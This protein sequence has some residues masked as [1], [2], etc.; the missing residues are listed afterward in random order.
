MWMPWN[1]SNKIF[2]PA[3]KVTLDRNVIKAPS[4]PAELW[5]EHAALK[6]IVDECKAR[7]RAG[8]L[9]PGEKGSVRPRRMHVTLL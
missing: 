6:R 2:T 7:R 3:V 8:S 4:D 9:P 5:D 1:T